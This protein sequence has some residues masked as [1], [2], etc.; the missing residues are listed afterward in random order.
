MTCQGCPKKRCRCIFFACPEFS[1]KLSAI[2]ED[3]DREEALLRQAFD[4]NECQCKDEHGK[5]LN[6]CSECPR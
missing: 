3:L 6:Q 5:A 4:P 2:D 1:E